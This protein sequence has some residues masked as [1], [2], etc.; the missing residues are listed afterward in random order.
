VNGSPVK[1]LF[2]RQWC[3]S[4]QALP[5]GIH[6]ILIRIPQIP[7]E[8]LP[9]E[10]L[11]RRSSVLSEDI[12]SELLFVRNESDSTLRAVWI[13]SILGIIARLNIVLIFLVLLAI[14]IYKKTDPEIVKPDLLFAFLF[15]LMIG[16]RFY[17]LSY[18]T[19]EGLH[20]DE[21]SVDH[22]ASFIRAGN[23][24][25][26]VYFYPPG[27]HYMTAGLENLA[28]WVL[29]DDLAF[30]IVPRFLSALF[31]ALS[32]LLVFSIGKAL[33]PKA[34]ARV[35]FVLFGFSFLPVYLAHFGIIEPTMVCFFLFGLRA[36]L[37]LNQESAAK[38][39]LKAGL[40][41]GLAVVMKQ[42]AAIL[43]FS[44]LLTYLFTNRSKSLHWSGITKIL[45]WGFGLLITF[46]LL[47]PYTILDFRGFMHDQLLQLRFLSGGLRN[48]LFFIEDPSGPT[49]ILDYLQEGVGYPI[50]ISATFGSILFW[51]YSQKGFVA[52]VP[53]TFLLFLIQSRAHAAPAHYPLLLCPLLCLLAAVTVYDLAN[54]FAIRKIL[55]TVLTIGVL[56]PPLMYIVTLERVLSGVDTRRQCS[57]WCYQNL[58]MGARIDYEQFGPRF[59]VQVFR[60]LMVP[61]WNRGTWDYYFNLRIPEYVIIDSETASVF[62]TKNKLEFPEEHEWYSSLRKH[63]V[64]IKEFSG[65]YFEQ[66]NPHILI[67]KIP[68]ENSGSVKK[69]N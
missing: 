37:N 11:W 53:L 1:E 23:L 60:S 67:Y 13:A 33:L 4:S 69:S 5:Q 42:T 3:M 15:L 55:I 22:V 8:S 50:L 41:A 52:I 54:R 49:K 56:I 66:Y 12:P 68:K 62:L 14:I 28:A 26:Q 44:F 59:L 65:M 17:G 2:R 34:C 38:E 6:D 51:R 58:P 9:L 47:S 16:L 43:G 57:E 21:R 36:L 40:I 20:P 31:S 64:M 32:C 46:L 18:L 39:Y 48:R 30:H 7:S 35:A 63:G 45:C 24:K 61:L 29:N 25:P 19:E 27:F 10:V